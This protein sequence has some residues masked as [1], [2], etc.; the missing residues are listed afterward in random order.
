MQQYFNVDYITFMHLANDFCQSDQV[1]FKLK[2]FT[3][4][5]TLWQS[6]NWPKYN[7]TKLAL[8][9]TAKFKQGETPPKELIMYLPH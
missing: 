5:T 1:A 6:T 2:H 8:C 9:S 4:K 7:Q 3:Y